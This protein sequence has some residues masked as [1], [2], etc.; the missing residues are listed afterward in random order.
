MERLICTF[1]AVAL[2]IFKPAQAQSVD[3]DYVFTKVEQ[4]ICSTPE[5][6]SL[7]KELERLMVLAT[8][9]KTIT[10]LAAREMRNQLARRCGES[11]DIAA[12][13]ID[14][15]REAILELSVL[16]GQWVEIAAGSRESGE[17]VSRYVILKEQLERAQLTYHETGKVV[18]LAS[19]TIELI[20]IHQFDGAGFI[21]DRLQRY[22]VRALE[23]R[24]D[25]GC[26]SL[27]ERHYWE[28]ALLASGHTCDN[29]FRLGDGS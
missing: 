10:S 29:G 13:L 6:D 20:K 17:L 26:R 15:E 28:R 23:S 12:C 19:V 14:R 1:F 5:L 16:T 3:C 25:S 8:D 9:K 2:A 7:D 21:P 11:D 4:A 18:D 24:L 27:R 22:E